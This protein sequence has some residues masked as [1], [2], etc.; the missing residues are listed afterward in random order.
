MNI[1]TFLWPTKTIVFS[2][3]V[4]L[5]KI[6]SAALFLDD[7]SQLHNVEIKKRKVISEEVTEN[8]HFLEE[9]IMQ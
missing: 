3:S 8:Q 2:N 6:K 4:K 9:Q 1:K 7:M 5:D